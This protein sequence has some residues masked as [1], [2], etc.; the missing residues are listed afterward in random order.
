MSEG[1]DVLVHVPMEDGSVGAL[2]KRRLGICQTSTFLAS[3]SKTYC[4]IVEGSWTQGLDFKTT[5]MSL[6]VEELLVGMILSVTAST[7]GGELG[8]L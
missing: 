5:A 6:D 8:P 4:S 1:L 3:V 7:L 2:E